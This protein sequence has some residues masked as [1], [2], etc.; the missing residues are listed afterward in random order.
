[1]IP[2]IKLKPFVRR[3]ALV[4]GCPLCGEI[5]K[6]ITPSSFCDLV[7]VLNVIAAILPPLF[8]AMIFPKSVFAALSAEIIRFLAVLTGDPIFTSP[9]TCKLSSG[10]IVPIPTLPL[11]LIVNLSMS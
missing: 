5:L 6:S 11:D 8:F 9:I 4:S 2:N 3:I 7:P 10:S 1:M